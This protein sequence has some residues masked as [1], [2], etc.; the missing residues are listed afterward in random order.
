MIWQLVIDNFIKKQLKKI[1]QKDAERLFVV[2]AGL[3][4]DPYAGDIEKM[5]GEENVWRR[6]VGAYR[7]LYEVRVSRKM[8]CVFDVR[9]RTSNTYQ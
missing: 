6:R 3:A 1:P 7:V 9:R 4:T 5:A 8:I 2:M